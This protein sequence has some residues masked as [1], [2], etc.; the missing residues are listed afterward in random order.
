MM[1]SD[2]GKAGKDLTPEEREAFD[3][4]LDVREDLILGKIEAKLAEVGGLTD[5]LQSLRALR[6]ET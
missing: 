1:T 5:R 6:G 2:S 3:S 4:Y